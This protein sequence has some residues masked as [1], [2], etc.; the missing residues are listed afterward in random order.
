MPGIPWLAS[1]RNYHINELRSFIKQRAVVVVVVGKGGLGMLRGR[2][3]KKKIK[4]E[5]QHTLEKGNIVR[6][7]TVKLQIALTA[8]RAKTSATL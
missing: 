8:G 7:R 5:L 4:C 6:G 1:H 2:K 3:K